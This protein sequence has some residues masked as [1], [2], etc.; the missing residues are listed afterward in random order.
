MTVITEGVENEA[1]LEQLKNLNCGSA[2]GFYFAKP[3]SFEDIKKFLE[4]K[5]AA[6]IP[7]NKIWRRFR[8]F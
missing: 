2:Q 3:M 1:Q 6:N 4:E 8:L 5:S 7:E